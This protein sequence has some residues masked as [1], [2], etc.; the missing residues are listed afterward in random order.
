MLAEANAAGVDGGFGEAGPGGDA[1]TGAVGADDVAS[2]E[3]LA[4][5]VD[6]SFFRVGSDALNGVLP[7][8]ADAEA[9][10]AVEEDLVEQSAADATAGS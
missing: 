8:E 6:E 1:G 9:G 5:G 10:G 2:A 3:G 4:I 7:V